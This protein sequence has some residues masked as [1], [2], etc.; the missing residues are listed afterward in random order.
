[1]RSRIYDNSRLSDEGLQLN[2]ID[3]AVEEQLSPDSKYRVL[4]QKVLNKKTQQRVY[5]FEN[6]RDAPDMNG[7]RAKNPLNGG[8]KKLPYIKSHLEKLKQ[9][10]IK[11]IIDFRAADVCSPKAIALAQEMDFK[12]VRFTI[13]D[14]WT[15][16]ELQE[17][18]KYIE[19]VNEGNFIA[20][21]ANGQAR[22]DLAMAI[23]YVFN[24]KAKNAPQFYYGNINR[25]SRVSVRDSIN[26]I[27]NAIEQNPEVISQYG[28]KSYD[29]FITTVRNRIENIL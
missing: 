17:M 14:T 3:K 29:D 19:A 27:L 25:S 21:C 6:L 12:Y 10:G 13:D 23:N 24:P 22:T 4:G 20:G 28:W 15:L 1:M 8:N 2:N 5:M 16:K 18:A 26:K 9:A 7:L 11:T